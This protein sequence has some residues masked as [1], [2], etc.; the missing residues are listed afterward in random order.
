MTIAEM[1]WIG[2]L[3]DAKLDP[4]TRK[5]AAKAPGTVLLGELTGSG[6]LKPGDVVFHDRGRFEIV[7]IEAFR[8]LLDHVESPCNVGLRVGTGADRDLFAKGQ[9]VRFER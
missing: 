1:F 7:A 5:L 2:A 3:A 9:Q 8:R 6:T 4:I